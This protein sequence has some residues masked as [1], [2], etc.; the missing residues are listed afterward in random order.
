[1][2]PAGDNTMKNLPPR[3]DSLCHCGTCQQAY[4]TAAEFLSKH[5][6]ELAVAKGSG[7]KIPCAPWLWQVTQ[8]MELIAEQIVLEGYIRVDEKSAID[9]MS[10]AKTNVDTSMTVVAMLNAKRGDAVVEVFHELHAYES[11]QAAK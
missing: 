1:M 11:A 7:D 8:A 5:M 4:E 2:T 3:H 6:P 9:F 10:A